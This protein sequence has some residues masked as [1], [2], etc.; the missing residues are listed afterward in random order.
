MARPVFPPD[1]SGRKLGPFWLAPGISRGNALTLLFGGSSLV[2]LMTFMAFVQPYLLQELLHVPEGEQGSLIGS[3]Q[4]MQ[5]VVFILLVSM[6]G[7]ISDKRGRR[8]IFVTGVIMLAG[9]FIIYPLATNVTQLVLFR[10]GYAVAIAAATVMMQ[11]C[12]AEYPQEA[13]RGKWQGLVGM[14]N[15]FGVVL[16]ALVL[17]KL[18]SWYQGMGYDSVEAVRLSY[19][20]FAAYLLLLAGLMRFSLAPRTTQ[21]RQSESLRKVIA[22]GAAVARSNMRITLAY[23]MAFA[24][25]GDLAILTSFFSLWVLQKGNELGW[26][27]AESTARAGMLFGLSQLVGLLWSYPMGMIID[28]IN[29]LT[30]MAIA[31]GLATAGY[32]FLGQMDVPEGRIVLAACVLVGMGEGSAMV[33]SGVMIG[34]EAPAEYRGAVLGTFALCGAAGVMVL[35]FLGGMAFDA[36]GRTAPFTMMGLVNGAVLLGVLV[37]RFYPTRPPPARSRQAAGTNPPHV[38]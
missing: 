5:E 35:S 6:I 1:P 4:S 7:A 36:L 8:V 19:W 13:T 32:L 24:S 25:R 9:A 27:A 3:L 26:S 14:C 12:Y 10:V 22:K 31:F 28:R 18:P 30:G 34:Q 33:A 21:V 2:C 16:M 29:R 17:A 15:G 20:T 11:V 23:G 37:L 38:P